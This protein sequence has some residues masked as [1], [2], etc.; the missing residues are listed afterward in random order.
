MTEFQVLLAIFGATLLV[1]FSII[2]YVLYRRELAL[3]VRGVRRRRNE[4]TD[5]INEILGSDNE[6]LRYYLDVVQNES[7]NSLRMRLVQAGYFS[8]SAYAK[9]N[10]IRLSVA[11]GVFVLVFFAITYFAPSVSNAVALLVGGIVGGLAFVLSA[12]V[13]ER[14]GKKRTREFRKLFPDFMDLL[15]VCVDAGLSVSAAIDR[16][17]REFLMTTPDFGMQLSIINLEVRAGRPLHEALHNFSKRVNV[18]EANTLAVLFKQSEELGA[19][20]S[21]TL[22]VYSKEMRTLRIVR[23]EEKANSLPVKMLFPMAFFMFPVN[24]II[25]LIPILFTIVS[26]FMQMSPG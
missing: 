10:L 21:K 7:E 19:S 4:T 8:R 26:V 25:V 11:A 3:N 18:E 5:K 1:S 13:L 9:F 14:I 17:T 15:L 24:L 6:Q 2:R 23:A 16:V 20:I 22:R 12:I